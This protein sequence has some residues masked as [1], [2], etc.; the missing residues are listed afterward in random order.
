[1][2]PNISN[3]INGIPF[4]VEF[5]VE[6]FEKAGEKEK[7]WRIG[8][9]ISTEHPDRQGEVVKQSGLDFSDFL[10]N[11]WFNDNHSRETTGILGY[12]S[13]VKSSKYEGKPATYVEGYLLKDYDRAKEVYKL[14]KALQ[15]TNRK[16][17][18]S[19]EGKVLRRVGIDGKIIAQAKVSNVAITNCP[20]NTATG[21]DILAKSIH[22]VLNAE[23]SQWEKALTAGSAIENPGTTAGGGFP[24]RTESMEVNRK[25]KKKRLVNIINKSQAMEIIRERFTTIDSENIERILLFVRR[26]NNV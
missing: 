16:L 11:G 21:M 14:G 24:L 26:M 2:A 7:E 4:K 10:K 8:G 22:A 25:K 17:G 1:M 12:P 23:T 15:R 3:Q 5:P 6:V 18:F 13:V 19:V 9:I 20:V